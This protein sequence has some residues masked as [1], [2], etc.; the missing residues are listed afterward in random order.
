MVA[1]DNLL[2][3]GQHPDIEKVRPMLF[4]SFGSP[5]Y[6][7]VGEKAGDAFSPGKELKRP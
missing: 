7:G 6:Y 5:L 4:G 3:H 1:D 2:S